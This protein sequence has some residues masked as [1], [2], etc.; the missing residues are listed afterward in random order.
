MVLITQVY[1]P[2]NL[3]IKTLTVTE[4]THFIMDPKNGAFVVFDKKMIRVVPID[5][6]LRIEAI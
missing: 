3:A 5:G 2:V 1:S 4:E 6:F